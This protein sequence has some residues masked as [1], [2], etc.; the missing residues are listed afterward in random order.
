MNEKDNILHELKELSPLLA[1]V[2]RINVFSVPENYF[3]GIASE[4]NARIAADSFYAGKE[5]SIV[6]DGYFDNL[7]GNI[8][9]K[10]KT[11]EQTVSEETRHISPVVAAI[12][13]RNIFSVPQRYFDTGFSIGNKKNAGKLVSMLQP[14][15]ILKYAAAVLVALLLTVSIFKKVNKKEPV[16]LAKV[17]VQTIQNTTAVNNTSTA[18][19]FDNALQQVSGVEIEQY[20]KQSGED[21]NAA[22][23]AAATDDESA[24]PEASEY[25]LNDNTLTEFLDK[26]NLKN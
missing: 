22:L 19:N 18:G 11:A 13:N 7:A 9:D 17:P 15:R 8:L 1:T 10:I 14:Q 23:V 4:L 20:L 12:G 6:P 3:D 2:P 21:V 25:L 24:L 26:N 5:G 16:T